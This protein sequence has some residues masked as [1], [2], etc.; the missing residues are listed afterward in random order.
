M[1]A[2]EKALIVNRS[3][4]EEITIYQSKVTFIPYYK[5]PEWLA[6]EDE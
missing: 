2:A 1:G 5:L 6:K 4:E 3:L